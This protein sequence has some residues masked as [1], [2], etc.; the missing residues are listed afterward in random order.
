M[1]LIYSGSFIVGLG[2]RILWR[3][4]IR[5]KMWRYITLSRNLFSR[6]RRML[7]R[8]LIGLFEFLVSVSE[9]P[10]ASGVPGSIRRGYN[11]N[12]IQITK[13]QEAI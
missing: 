8:N 1:V 11:E 13:V 9:H 3:I 2:N 4:R 10:T 6:S 12:M 7:K 5:M